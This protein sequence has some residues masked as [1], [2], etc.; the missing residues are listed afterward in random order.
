MYN[1]F[2]RNMYYSIAAESFS[3]EP[4]LSTSNK[5]TKLVRFHEKQST[6]NSKGYGKS[7]LYLVKLLRLLKNEV[8][9]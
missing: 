7:V 4:K 3:N 2:V 8:S 9:L 1:D 5:V 6:L